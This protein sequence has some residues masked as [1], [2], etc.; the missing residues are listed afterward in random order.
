[1]YPY[2]NDVDADTANAPNADAAAAYDNAEFHMTL[3]CLRSIGIVFASRLG[4][5]DM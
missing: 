4:M 5:R 3:L 2:G 1:M